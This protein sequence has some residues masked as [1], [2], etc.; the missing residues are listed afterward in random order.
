[1]RE[2][3]LACV[4]QKVWGRRFSRPQPLFFS[5]P[6]LDI[7][8]QSDTGRRALPVTAPPV[9]STAVE[10]HDVL[11]RLGTLGT[12]GD[13]LVCAAL[14]RAVSAVAGPALREIGA[15]DAYGTLTEIGQP[16]TAALVQAAVDCSQA[17]AGGTGRLAGAPG[18]R[19]A[20]G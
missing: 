15:V 7:E 9:P 2:H 1:M 12:N 18:Q 3:L 11:D 5:P 17:V 20:P 6:S 10:L 14:L 19:P 8:H 4:V 13:P 16:S